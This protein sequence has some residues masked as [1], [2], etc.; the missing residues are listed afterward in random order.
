MAAGRAAGHDH[1]SLDDVDGGLPEMAVHDGCAGTERDLERA[2]AAVG[3]ATN[4]GETLGPL[5]GGAV[6]CVEVFEHVPDPLAVLRDPP[7][8]PA[9]VQ[10]GEIERIATT[11]VRAPNWLSGPIEKAAKNP[12]LLFYKLRTNAYKFSWML[13]PL[14]VPFVWLLFPFSRRF[15]F[16]DHTVFVTY[17]LSFMTLLVVTAVLIGLAGLPQ[18]AGFAMLIPPV[19]IYRQLK[20]S[21]G[22]SGWGALV[23]TILLCAFAALAL[24]LFL[25]M[26]F[27]L[28]LF[29]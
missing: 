23:R 27:G 4:G 6:L 25:L 1:D 19:H 3:V 7:R 12:D 18:V 16:Y 21:Y 15:K 26:L 17:S 20:G 10:S 22:L 8:Q 24:G 5:A 11:Q 28:G 14:S 9:G 29:D 2:N 13:I